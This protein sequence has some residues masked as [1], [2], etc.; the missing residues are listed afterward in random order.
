VLLVGALS[1]ARPGLFPAATVWSGFG[2]GYGYVPLILPVLGLAW[3]GRPA[4][5]RAYG[6]GRCDSLAAVPGG[7]T[8]EARDEAP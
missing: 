4:T 7:P 1:L 3:L 8:G 6:A 2:A 5:R